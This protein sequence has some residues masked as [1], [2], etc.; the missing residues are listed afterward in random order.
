MKEKEAKPALIDE[1]L[2]EQPVDIEVP[3]DAADVQEKEVDVEEDEKVKTEFKKLD[4]SAFAAL[5]KEAADRKKEAEEL[6]KKLEGYEK[7]QRPPTQPQPKQPTLPERDSSRQREYING[8][9][10]PET[11][12]EW[13]ALARQ[14]WQV[15]VDLR[16]IISARRVNEEARRVE[17]ASGELEKSKQS[18]L[19]K[20]PELD[21]ANSAKAQIY[22]KILDKNPDYLTMSKGPLYAMR[23]MEEE[24][25]L[26][27]YT[28]DQIFDTK[29]HTTQVEETRI[30]RGALTT[31]GRMPE[32]GKRTV[33]LSKDDLEFC[34][35]NAIEPADYAREKL[36]QETNK[37]GAQL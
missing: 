13:D 25:E 14:N 5:R 28:K 17:K 23:D 34:K 1:L 21:D 31:G 20:H 36:A 9:P 6:R 29:K 35:A 19:S 16:S 18:V 37:R 33:Q 8:V 32:K 2:D 3:E 24:M 10:I 12:E 15:A 4:H 11:K 26:L 7:P 30:S 27:G 22:L